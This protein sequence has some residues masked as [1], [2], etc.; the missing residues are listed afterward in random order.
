MSR[1]HAKREDP[2]ERKTTK[3][4]LYIRSEESTRTGGRV[5]HGDRAL[6]RSHIREE[7]PILMTRAPS[8]YSY[9][10]RRQ[11][12]AP[13]SVHSAYSSKL[14]RRGCVA[15]TAHSAYSSKLVRR[16]CVAPTAW[17]V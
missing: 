12:A 7:A 14:V 1:P 2:G 8:N 17:G 5:S 10:R 4:W 9:I 3:N 15:P 11:R 16:G 6:P 13:D